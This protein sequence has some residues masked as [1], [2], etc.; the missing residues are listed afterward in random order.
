MAAV[1]H[2]R[3]V[4][5]ARCEL[6]CHACSDCCDCESASSSSDRVRRLHRF[7]WGLTAATIAWNCIEALIA[8]VSGLMARSIALV[9]FGLDSIVEVSSALIIMWRLLSHSDDEEANERAEQR[10]VRLIALSFFAIAIYVTVE[11]VMKLLGMGEPPERSQVGLILVGLSLFVMPAL[12]WAKRQVARRLGSVALDADA[13][14][15]KICTYLSAV[16]LLGLGANALLG[17]WWMDPLAGLVVAGLAIRE[18][19][20]AWASGDLCCEV[21]ALRAN[22]AQQHCLEACCPG[23]PIP[24]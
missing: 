5:P 1:F 10:A 21:D 6:Q 11:S 13:N 7:A 2:D 4:T 16:V 17:W 19:R 15:T 8:L 9:G 23:C 22:L 12:M 3:K 18:G 20:A 14:Q 24:A